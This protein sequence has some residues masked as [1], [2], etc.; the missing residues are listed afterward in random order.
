MHFFKRIG[1]CF[2]ILAAMAG[3]A[4]AIDATQSTPPQ[5]IG[6]NQLTIGSRTLRLPAGNWNLVAQHQGTITN[7]KSTQPI[8]K[9]W[10][11]YALDAKDGVFVNGIELNLTESSVATSGWAPE[12]CKAQGYLFMDDFNSGFKTPECLLVFKRAG[13]LTRSASGDFYPQASN[14]L[15]NQKIKSPGPVYEIMYVKYASNEFGQVRLWVP[16]SSLPSDDAAV[17]FAKGLPE[18]LRRFSER[19]DQEATLPTLPVRP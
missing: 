5:A 9:S 19:R 11:V 10:R 18:Q 6:D 7:T 14:W 17:A 15:A 1:Q 4:H 12:P 13:H 3:S 2:G 8:G 16:V